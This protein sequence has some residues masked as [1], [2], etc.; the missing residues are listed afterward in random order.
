M[1]H[2]AKAM[3][4]GALMVGATAL[5]ALANGHSCHMREG[6]GGGESCRMQPF[7]K[8]WGLSGR[9]FANRGGNGNVYT[10]MGLEMLKAHDDGWNGGFGVYR[11]MNLGDQTNVDATM[12]GG[13]LF[14]RDFDMGAMSLGLGVLLGGGCITTV[15]P[16]VT[17]SNFGAFFAGEPR[18]SLGFNLGPSHRLAL[19][20]SYLATTRMSQVSGPAVT[21]TL[22]TKMPKR[23]VR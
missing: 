23:C 15:S 8:Q 13:F 17:F 1:G 5:P 20:G 19:T 21:L 22:S 18:V 14:G 9:A 16:T 3:A 4:I 11:G 10:M 12:H 6:G 2:A 7:A